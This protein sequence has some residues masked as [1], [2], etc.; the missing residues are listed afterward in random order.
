MGPNDAVF[1]TDPQILVN[2]LFADDYYSLKM[3][4]TSVKWNG[5]TGSM[6]L[7]KENYR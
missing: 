2:N 6:L 4:F 7:N 1:I 3:N 5:A